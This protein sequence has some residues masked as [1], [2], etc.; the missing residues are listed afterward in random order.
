MLKRILCVGMV[1]LGMT[2]AAIASGAEREVLEAILIRVDDRIAIS[3]G[4]VDRFRHGTGTDA[5][6]A[7]G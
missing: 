4:F 7:R 6:S 3:T 2:V 5:E 1:S